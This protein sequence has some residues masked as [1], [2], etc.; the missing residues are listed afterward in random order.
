MVKKHAPVKSLSNGGQVVVALAA[1]SAVIHATAFAMPVRG[2]S[3]VNLDESS[4]GERRLQG[5]RLQNLQGRGVNLSVGCGAP[6]PRAWSRGGAFAQVAVGMKIEQDK[7]VGRDL[8]HR[9]A[10][11]QPAPPEEVQLLSE[12]LNVRAAPHAT[13]PKDVRDLV[14][15]S[16]D[17]YSS[18]AA[19]TACDF[20]GRGAASRPRACGL[21]HNVQTDGRRW[22]G[23]DLVR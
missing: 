10:A 16:A 6:R 11:V 1:A 3:F 21:V 5:H 17:P 15:S 4:G 19:G 23:P 13:H 14:G 12:Q 22:V 2:A 8:S 9:F 18:H 20:A 7:R